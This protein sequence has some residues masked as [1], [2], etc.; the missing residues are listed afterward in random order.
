MSFIYTAFGEKINIENFTETNENTNNENTNNENTNNENTSNENT[1]NENTNNDNTNNDNTNENTKESVEEEKKENI[2]YN[3]YSHIRLYNL[4]KTC[5][6]TL[7]PSYTEN[8]GEFALSLN[9][10]DIDNNLISN[11]IGAKLNVAPLQKLMIKENDVEVENEKV[12]LFYIIDG[13]IVMKKGEIK[14]YLSYDHETKTLMI[15]TEDKKINIVAL[16]DY[17]SSEKTTL[18]I[19]D[20]YENNKRLSGTFYKVNVTRDTFYLSSDINCEKLIKLSG[21]EVLN[22]KK[23]SKEKL[24]AMTEDEKKAN[25]PTLFAYKPILS[26][27]MKNKQVDLDMSL[28]LEEEL[29]KVFPNSINYGKL[30]K[31]KQALTDDKESTLS[32]DEKSIATW[33]KN[34]ETEKENNDDKKKL[35][36]DLI[37]LI[38]LIIVA[39]KSFKYYLV[40]V[41]Q[42]ESTNHLE[43]KCKVSSKIKYIV[44]TVRSSTAF[45]KNTN[46]SDGYLK[47]WVREN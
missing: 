1:N 46:N 43:G 16:F 15:T 9:V 11:E 4:D 23:L 6:I 44:D 42:E 5:Y 26:E 18:T 13:M 28:E 31:V 32:D 22:L 29:K 19:Y 2:D 41:I 35:W 37:V 8:N 10:I 14:N 20:N 40:E 38:A 24:D 45:I 27:T 12:G 47:V 39:E 33:M 7:Y 17:S 25:T 34:L 3:V 30:R 21:F 36:Q